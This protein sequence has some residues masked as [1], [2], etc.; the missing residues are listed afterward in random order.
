MKKISLTLILL[1]FV[2]IFQACKKDETAS[3]SS[4]SNQTNSPSALEGSWLLQ[5][6]SSG[7]RIT[8]TGNVFTINSG[9]VVIQG[10]FTYVNTTMNCV[11]TSRS[12]ANSGSLTPDNFTGNATLSNNGTIVTFTNFTG[13]WYAVFSTWYWKI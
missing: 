2:L 1:F 10:T 11:V 13:N 9:T 8:F 12:G 6:I 3:K 7:S 4:S 5:N